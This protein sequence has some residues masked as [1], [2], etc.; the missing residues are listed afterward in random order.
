MGVEYE[1]I[2]PEFL[3]VVDQSWDLLN[4]IR[5]NQNLGLR[6]LSIDDFTPREF[7]LAGYLSSELTRLQRTKPK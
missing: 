2:E 4:A 6:P 3:A 1:P 7:E 5:M